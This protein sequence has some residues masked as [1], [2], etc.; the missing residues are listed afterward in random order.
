MAMLS[1]RTTL[2]PAF[3]KGDSL[4]RVYE[5]PVVFRRRLSSVT[6]VVVVSITPSNS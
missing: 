3:S 1:A 2:T 4:K 5:K 6:A